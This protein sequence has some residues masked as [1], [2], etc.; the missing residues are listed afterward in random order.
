MLMISGRVLSAIRVLLLGLVALSVSAIAQ[1]DLGVLRF[2]AYGGGLLED[3]KQYLGIPFEILTGAKIEWTAAN[4]EVFANKLTVA[5]GKAAPFDLVMLDEPWNS[6][7]R[8]RGLAEKLDEARVPTLRNVKKEFLQ[9]DNAGVCLFSFTAGIIYNKDKFRENGIPPPTRWQDL[10]NPKLSGHVGTQT[11]A[12]TAP[13]HLLAAYAVQ[14]GDPPTKWDRAIDEVAKIKF[15]SFSSG[16]ADL[17]AKIEAGEVW[18][19][20]IANGRAY[21]MIAKGLPVEFVLPENGDGTKGGLSCTAI[22][23][24]KGAPNRA[25]AERFIA[26]ALTS[27]VQLMTVVAKTSYG[28]V[29]D[30][31][32]SVLARAP[33]IGNQVPYGQATKNMLRLTWDEA[34]LKNFPK[35]VEAW[36]RK[37]QNR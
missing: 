37:I 9:P 32:D 29:T 10:A 27:D 12:A 14:L 1:G 2:G 3:Q 34:E 31:V 21:A 11:L 18:A 35:Y 36:N 24:P 6:I 28:P 16:A 20:P 8:V 13:K 19:A 17:V 4:E 23:I 15:H 33:A 7:V 26:F 22:V 5:G 25:L 30:A